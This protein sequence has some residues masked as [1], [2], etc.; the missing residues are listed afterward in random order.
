[1]KTD[2]QQKIIQGSKLKAMKIYQFYLFVCLGGSLLPATV[3]AT[4]CT[5]NQSPV[6]SNCTDLYWDTGDVT[7]RYNVGSA[8]ANAIVVRGNVG[9]LTN[10]GEITSSYLGGSDWSGAAVSDTMGDVTAIMNFRRISSS[11]SAAIGIRSGNTVSTLYNSGVI[12]G[13]TSGVYNNGSITTLNNDS[14]GWIFGQTAYGLKNDS[15]GY[16]GV[17]TNSGTIYGA[18]NLY[19]IYNNWHSPKSLDIFIPQSDAGARIHGG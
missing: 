7:I 18:S 5:A 16:I 15:S 13:H 19:G 17:I 8:Y 9:T 11:T 3:L 6:I 14:S 1:L 4:T 12:D 2:N 10:N